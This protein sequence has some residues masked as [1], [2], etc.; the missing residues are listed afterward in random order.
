ME[1]SGIGQVPAWAE[2]LLYGGHTNTVM[3]NTETNKLFGNVA[4]FRH[5]GMTATNK[6][7]IHVHINRTLY[8]GNMTTRLLSRNVNIK[9]YE[10]SIFFLVTLHG[11]GT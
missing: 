5:F 7:C 1:S 6:N 9:I 11:R 2:V 10:I 3:K 4:K 8:T